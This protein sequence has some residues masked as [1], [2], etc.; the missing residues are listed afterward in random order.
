MVQPVEQH[1]LS[2]A[3]EASLGISWKDDLKAYERKR[4]HE[5]DPA[6]C[7]GAPLRLDP[8][9]VKLAE[10][11]WD[12]LLGRFRDEQQEA[13]QQRFEKDMKE[14]FMNRAKDIQILRETP[15]DIVTN[16]SRLDPVGGEPS[17]TEKAERSH[18]TSLTNYNIVSNLPLESHHYERPDKRPWALERPGRGRLVPAADVKDFNPITN[19]YLSDHEAKTGRDHT[20]N[21]LDAAR[22]YRQR[23]RFD[24]L[25]Q[26]FNCPEVEERQRYCDDAHTVEYAL[27]YQAAL[28]PS[29]KGSLTAYYDTLSHEV[30]NDAALNILDCAEEHRTARFRTRHYVD[31]VKKHQEI[32]FEDASVL[33][34]NQMVA[35]ER[36]EEVARRGFDIVTNQAF[37]SRPGELPLRPPFTV[38]RLEPWE[39][40]M[41]DR[42][43]MLLPGP[44]EEAVADAGAVSPAGAPA[45]QPSSAR[46]PRS[47][48]SKTGSATGGS[49]A[50]SARAQRS[51]AAD[52]AATRRPGGVAAEALAM[53][54]A[55]A[56]VDA[57]SERASHQAA[58]R[59]KP[60]SGGP[61]SLSASAIQRLGTPR[62]ARS[63]PP[64]GPMAAVAATASAGPAAAADLA[65]RMSPPISVAPA[66]PPAPA[67]PGS[68][69]GSVY[70]RPKMN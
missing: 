37:G 20:L 45:S 32:L 43:D 64:A 61:P 49:G 10:R 66:A 15:F 36:F 22:K 56:A 11:A 14:Q 34:K 25:R 69:V 24:P 4:R 59:P 6:F 40:V 17:T 28:P 3:H 29:Y 1:T 31:Y 19:R 58:P 13:R 16:A 7:Q 63:R 68:P 67:I 35:H 23:S 52:F 26:V 42:D 47:P 50:L 57:P 38:Q 8:K 2:A 70:S 51:P 46:V 5:I 9:V 48:R 30:K 33:Q 21:K 27:R 65:F 41:Q 60:Q 54:A 18:P 62:S 55:E 39:K 12:P 53:A 44:V